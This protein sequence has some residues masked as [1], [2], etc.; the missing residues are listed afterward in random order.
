MEA[1]RSEGGGWCGQVREGEV[2]TMGPDWYMRH[3]AKREK[4]LPRAGSRSI[5]R[6]SLLVGKRT[7]E[8][9][10]LIWWRQIGS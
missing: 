2:Q 4:G 6:R 10:A 8:H 1:G 3:G 7:G 5:Q 9:I